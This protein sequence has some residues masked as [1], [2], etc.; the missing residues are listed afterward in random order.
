MNNI[1]TDNGYQQLEDV[2]EQGNET[3][4]TMNDETDSFINEG[5]G[6]DEED[7][8]D[9]DENGTG[10]VM[11]APFKETR[12]AHKIYVF[13]GFLAVIL[14]VSLAILYFCKGDDGDIGSPFK[15]IFDKSN[16]ITLNNV[17]SEQFRPQ[18]K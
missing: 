13:S 12:T 16:R 18:K 15:K 8:E 2:A 1:S 3:V 7:E 14:I 11:Q 5:N 17:F 10:Y 6:E 9:D 4:I